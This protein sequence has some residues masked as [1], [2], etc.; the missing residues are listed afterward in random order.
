MS[1]DDVDAEVHSLFAMLDKDDNGLVD[2]DELSGFLSDQMH[3]D[4]ESAKLQASR[5]MGALGLRDDQ[6]LDAESFGA[7]ASQFVTGPAPPGA[8]SRRSEPRA[9]A[10]PFEREVTYPTLALSPLVEC[11]WNAVNIS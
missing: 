9:L 11:I 2:L 7:V 1:D 5:V 6:G 3:L 10:R 8:P 4:T